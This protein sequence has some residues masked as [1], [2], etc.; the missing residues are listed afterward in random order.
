MAFEDSFKLA[1]KDWL[2]AKGVEAVEVQ[3]VEQDTYSSGG[4]ESCYFEAIE[5]NITYLDNSG[6]S[7]LY[8]YYGDMSELISQL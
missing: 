1:V 7:R 5:V 8:S 2:V 4:C 3:V 6:Q